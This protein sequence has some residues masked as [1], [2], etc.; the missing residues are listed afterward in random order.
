MEVIV[1]EMRLEL[2]SDETS[3]EFL[4]EIVPRGKGIKFHNVIASKNVTLH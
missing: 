3:E 4:Y 1:N 2:Y